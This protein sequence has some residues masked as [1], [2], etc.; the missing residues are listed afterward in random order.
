MGP[1]DRGLSRKQ[2]LKQ[3]DGSLERLQTDYV[4]L[5]QCHRYDDTRPLR[6]DDGRA[7][8]GRRGG[9]GAADRVLR[10]AGGQDPGGAGAAR[11]WRSSCP[12][13]RSTARCGASPRPRSSRVCEANGITQI[14]WSPLAQGVLTGKYQPGEKVPADSRAANKSMNRFIKQWLND[15]TLTRRAGAAADRRRGGRHARRSSRWRGCCTSRNVTRGD[16]R[17]DAARAG[18]RERRGR[19]RQAQRRHARRD[20]RRAQNSGGVVSS[21]SI[22][23]PPSGAAVAWKSSSKPSSGVGRTSRRATS[24][25]PDAGHRP[26]A[27]GV[28]ARGDRVV[29]LDEVG[30]DLEAGLARR[31]D[32]ARALGARSGS[33]CRPRTASASPGTARGT[34][35]RE[36]AC[37]AGPSRPARGSRGSGRG[38][39]SSCP[40]PARRRG[41]RPPLREDVTC[42]PFARRHTGTAYFSRELEP[43]LTI[44][45]GDTVV[46]RTLGRRLG[47]RAVRRRRLPAAPRGGATRRTTATRST[48]PVAIRGAQPGMTLRIDIGAI[49]PG[50]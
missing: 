26:L 46:F 25:R 9:Q 40:S 12:R 45:P 14:V 34:P 17:R 38:R 41:S 28:A 13:S 23:Q 2:I 29:D 35:P 6:G 47:P 27:R 48:G 44:D 8:R 1:R 31:R 3:I 22:R 11:A 33:C 4:D 37:A 43:V 21:G 5:Y 30:D 10:V 42:D 32:V 15:D 24:R 16:R 39:A 19:R 18:A 20:R 50:P 7:D 49:V 36:R